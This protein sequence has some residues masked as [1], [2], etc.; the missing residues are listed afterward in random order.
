LSPARFERYVV[1]GDSTAEGLDDP[2]GRGGYRGWADR[3]AE[4]L[5]R[6]QGGIQYA[7]IAV[8]GRCAGEIRR[9]QL[10]RAL[11]LRP[12]LAA[13]VAGTNDLFRP[14]FDAD[15]VAGEL[16]AMLEALV[17]AGATVVFLTVPDL[18]PVMPLARPLR[19]RIRHLA[20]AFAEASARTGALLVDITAHPVAWDPRLWS[21]DRLHANPLGHARLADAV[22]HA[23]GR[24]GSSADWLA[25][26]PERKP[27]P[28][29]LALRDEIGW[30]RRFLVPWLWR[31]A[32]GR[33][34]GDG[35][36]AKRPE[37]RP[38]VY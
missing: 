5:A 15:A 3:L 11:A 23:L 35:R 38:V 37:L 29:A 27:R 10:E 32:R 8:R 1:I 12:D 6:E 21:E 28:I 25:P 26:L 31:H 36:Q 30:T 16:E 18:G 24:P 17:R 33:S 13:I 20:R 22:A 7:N 9:E 19:P 14:R 2:D 34:S 4:R